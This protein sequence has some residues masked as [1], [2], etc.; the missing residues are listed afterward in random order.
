MAS[1]ATQGGRAFSGRR[2][3]FWY[4]D[5]LPPSARKALCDAAFNWA[6][7]WAYSQW[8]RGKP[9]F[10]TGGDIAARIAEADARQ[11]ARDHHQVWGVE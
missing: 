5:R 2:D 6:A 3:D 7:G 10:K 8:Q 11:I 4:L 9:G 1:N